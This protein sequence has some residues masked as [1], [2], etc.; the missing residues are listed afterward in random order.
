MCNRLVH[1]HLLVIDKIRKQLAIQPPLT[2]Q[3]ERELGALF[4]SLPNHIV[5]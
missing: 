2:A 3:N 4:E 5:E 1:N